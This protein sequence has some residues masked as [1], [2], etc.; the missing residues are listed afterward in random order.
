MPA[1]CAVAPQE[2]EP[3]ADTELTA[4][5]A[6]VNHDP[7]VEFQAPACWYPQGNRWALCPG[8]ERKNRLARATRM[9]DLPRPT[10][11]RR[12]A[13]ALFALGQYHAA[14]GDRAQ[15]IAMFDRVLSSA[16]DT[17]M[18]LAERGRVLFENGDHV[19]AL[20]LYRKALSSEPWNVTSHVNVGMFLAATGRME[21]AAGL[22]RS[23]ARP[24][25]RE[26]VAAQRERTTR[27]RRRAWRRRG[28]TPSRGPS[29][30]VR[31]GRG[32]R[33]RT[34]NLRF[35]RP[36]LCLIELLPCKPRRGD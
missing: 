35:W 8:Y 1:G 15:A 6:F 7:G 2:E 10:R 3:A 21:E 12:R 9:P 24:R 22:A 20:E 17:A 18:A 16:P 27:D 30:A 28:A 19:Q 14:Q 25:C 36:A 5:P 11:T 29:A 34:C 32:D 31:N 26:R 23:A 13:D 4:T 33:N